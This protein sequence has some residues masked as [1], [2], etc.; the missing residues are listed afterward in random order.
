MRG[1]LR[2]PAGRAGVTLIEL[3]VAL[4][5]LGVAATV[6][7]LAVRAMPEPDAA[8]KRDGRIDAAR[9]RSLSER[10]PVAVELADSGALLRAVVFPDGR[11]VADPA[12]QV[13]PLSGRRREAAR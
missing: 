9:R 1:A 7:G 6:T 12:L 5:I 4:A 8:Q 3:A 2:L 13:D 11:V 10:H